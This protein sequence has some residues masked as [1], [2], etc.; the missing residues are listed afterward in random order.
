MSLNQ[1]QIELV[2]NSFQQVVPIAETAAALFYQRLFDTMPEATTLFKNT[3]IK[4]QGKKLMQMLTVAVAGLTKLNGLVPA[5]KALGARHVRYGVKDEHYQIVG[6]VLL[7]TLEQGLGAAFTDEV[8]T[9]WALVYSILAE[10]A[11]TGA[12]EALEAMA[13]E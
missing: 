12:H 8:K 1:H 4:E 3:D 10:T 11:I 2:Q 6:E 5:V 7:W 9:A 13:T